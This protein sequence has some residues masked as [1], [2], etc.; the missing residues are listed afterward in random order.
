MTTRSLVC[1]SYMYVLVCSERNECMNFARYF[2]SD[3]QTQHVLSVRMHCSFSLS[4]PTPGSR[5]RCCQRRE[6]VGGA[7]ED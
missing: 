7:R 3:S 2:P 6:R 4:P 5:R 1:F